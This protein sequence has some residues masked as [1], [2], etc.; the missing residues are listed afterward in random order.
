M[1]S[2]EEGRMDV[3]QPKQMSVAAIRT[4]FYTKYFSEKH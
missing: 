1:L 3:R 2:S 4:M